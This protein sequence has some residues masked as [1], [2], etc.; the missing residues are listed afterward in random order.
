MRHPDAAIPANALWSTPFARWRGALARVSSL[1]VAVAATRAA[2][3]RLPLDEVD[4]LVLGWTVPQPEIFYGAPTVARRV[5]LSGVSG[6]MI[7]QA[8]A[9]SVACLHAAATSLHAGGGAQL[10]VTAD[11]V[12]NGPMLTWGSSGPGGAEREE[13]WVRAAFARDPGTDRGMLATAE[14]V[15]RDAGFRRSDADALAVLRYEQYRASSSYEARR[16]HTV[17]VEVIDPDGVPVRLTDDEGVRTRSTEGVAA[18]RS[19]VRDGVHTAATQT[20]PADGAAGALVTRTAHAR[21]LASGGPVVTVLASGFARV[22][23]GRMPEALVPA[24]RAALD[25]V[26]LR[27][28]DVDAITT[29]NPFAVNDL[30]FAREMGVTLESMNRVGSS[31]VF[32]HPQG[33]TGLRSIAELVTVLCLRGGGVGLFSGCAAGDS[34]AAIVV[35]VDY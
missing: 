35:R 31:L 29:H 10:V 19:V 26:D 30:Y 6:P 5:G 21:S 1:D 27:I 25:S 7:G 16:R 3:S 20:H 34:G 8:C 18:E 32:G 23:S 14:T 24:A 15:A 9:T 22:G 4:G 11:R 33:P 17:P 12:S 13:S 28:E 2:T